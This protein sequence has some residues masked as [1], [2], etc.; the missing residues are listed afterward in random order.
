MKANIGV[1]ELHCNAEDIYSVA[2]LAK[3]C[4]ANITIFTT[5]LQYERV[6]PFF[7]N[8]KDD[9]NWILQ[10]EGETFR[11]FLK[12]I[13]KYC[14][15]KIDLLFINTFLTLPHHQIYYYFFRLKCKTVHVVGRIE[16][17][18]DKGHPIKY[19]SIK[20]FTL[21]VLANV[22]QY[23]ANKTFSQFDGIWV[24]NKDAYNYAV[25][26]GYKKK[27]AYFSVHHSKVKVQ[28]HEY[29]G[30][31]KFITIGTLDH[32]RR[33]YNGLLNVF[34]KLFDS[35]NTNIT[36]T[37][38]GAPVDRKGFETIDRCRKLKEKGLDIIFYTEYV[39]E[40]VVNKKIS[41]A[42]IIINPNYVNMYGAGTFGAIIKAMQFAKPGI[43]PVNS[44]HYEELISSSLFYNKVEE[45]QSIIE[46]LLSNPENLNKLSRN[47]LVNSEKFSFEKVANKFKEFV[48]KKHLP[49]LSK[50]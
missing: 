37:L 48:L 19:S 24:D 30:K 15:N 40:E 46:N 20:Q 27:I 47:A 39:S 17:F 1:M 44:L 28:S 18:F 6:L 8:S 2:S 12:R 26:A 36:L 10:Q 45:L 35:G 34:E 43:Y 25:S 21:S 29:N 14:N 49:E 50:D 11:S 41:S 4:N 13:V 7:N 42:D 32:Y 9:Y 38:L 16:R 23:I 31:M 33:D 22:S 3:H 5:K